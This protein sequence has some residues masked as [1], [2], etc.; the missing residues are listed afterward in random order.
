MIKSNSLVK[1]SYKKEDVIILL[2]D[3]TD[4]MTELPAEIREKEIQSGKHYSTMLPME[5]EP[6]KEYMDL[7]YRSLN[8]N[9]EKIAEHIARL[10]ELIMKQY[11]KKAGFPVIIS[12]ARAGI[13]VGILIKRYIKIKYGIDVMHYAIS[14]IRDVGIDNN[15]MD[16]IYDREISY[17]NNS[18]SNF[19]FVDGWTGKGVIKIQ[20]ED[21][22][23]ELKKDEKWNGLMDDL[24]VISDPSNVTDF[25][26]TH[27]DYLIS[28]SC[29]NSTVSGLVSRSILNDMV[30]TKNGDFHGGV[31]FEKFENIDESNNFINYISHYFEKINIADVH[32]LVKDEEKRGATLALY[33]CQ[34]YDISDY[35]KVKPGIGET[36][37]V[38]LRRVPWKIFINRTVCKK[39]IEDLEHIIYMCNKKRIP[40]EREELGDYKV[41]GVIKEFL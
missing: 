10:S 35:K 15:A 38:L 11:N 37:R 22:V 17:G 6:D 25:C 5:K 21:A 27:E 13:P 16:Y 32:P 4:K 36:T 29:L 34:K 14:I 3:L 30:D 24:Y 26:G 18:V 39:D 19:F 31:Y 7:Y 40:I 8:K 23:K 20:L 12:L 1:T 41:C 28:S 9:G 33:L 2:K